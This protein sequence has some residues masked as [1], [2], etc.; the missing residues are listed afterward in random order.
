MHMLVLQI[1]QV[2][3]TIFT[4]SDN[5]LPL[6]FVSHSGRLACMTKQYSEP[7]PIPFIRK[8]CAHK[9]EAEIVEAEENFRRYIRLLMRISERLCREEHKENNGIDEPLDHPYNQ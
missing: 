1:A 4:V 2:L 6:P 5:I 7:K 9:S 8:L 3:R